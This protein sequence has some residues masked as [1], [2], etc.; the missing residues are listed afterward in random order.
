MVEIEN[1]EDY[2]LILNQTAVDMKSAYD[3]FL[4]VHEPKGVLAECI[5]RFL[6]LLVLLCTLAAFVK[7]VGCNRDLKFVM[8]V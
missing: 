5:Q 2:I 1:E 8:S 7:V 4:R 3:D 6:P